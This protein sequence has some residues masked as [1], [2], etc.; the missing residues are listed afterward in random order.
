M[1]SC[2]P[3][4]DV[5]YNYRYENIKNQMMEFEGSSSQHFE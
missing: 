2:R 5:I 4:G 1:R 3:I